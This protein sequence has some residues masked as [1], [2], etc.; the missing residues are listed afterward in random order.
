MTMSISSIGA[1]PSWVSQLAGQNPLHGAFGAPNAVASSG[2]PT[3][4]PTFTVRALS[5]APGGSL[6]QDIL[7]TLEQMGASGTTTSSSTSASRGSTSTPASQQTQ[8]LQNFMASLMQAL[9]QSSSAASLYQVHGHG[10]GHGGH[11]SSQL[12]S[13]IDEV[14]GNDGTTPATAT[15]APTGTHSVSNLESA[16]QTLM[17]DLSAQA[18]GSP[19]SSSAVTGAT[20]ASAATATAT[21]STPG[22][23][24]LQQFLQ[25][26]L[27]NLQNQGIAGEST[28]LLLNAVA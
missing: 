15:G 23:A 18:S 6:M 12:Q 11:M 9:H 13:L 3:S 20:S 2:A 1:F 14:D 27:Q 8:D 16:F 22:T 21:A 19:G 10:H 7:A 26:L 5:T 24:T 25:T 17:Q 28:G 4:A